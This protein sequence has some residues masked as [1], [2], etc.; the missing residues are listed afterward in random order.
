MNDRA[1]TVANDETLVELIRPASRRVV[2]MAPAVSKPVADAIKQKWMMLGA[3]AVSVIVDVDP[4]V[5]RLGYGDFEALGI[6]EQTAASLGTTLNRQNGIRI[7]LLISDDTTVVYSPTP[8][9]IE[10]GPEKISTPNAVILDSPPD[11]VAS[12]LGQGPNGIKDQT[13]GLDKAEKAKIAE[14]KENLDRNPPQRFDIAR[15]CRVFN[16][17]FEFVEFELPGL[18]IQQRKVTIPSDLIGLIKDKTIQ[19]M[20]E[21]SFKLIDESSELSGKAFQKCKSRIIKEYLTLLPGYKYVVLR[22]VKPKFVRKV[23]QLT[24]AVKRFQEHV[25]ADLQAAVDDNRKKLVDAW[26][27]LVKESPPQRWNK[28]YGGM[29]SDQLARKLLDNDL[30][31]AFLSADSLV[32]EMKVKLVFKGVTYELLQ[33][34]EFINLAR[35]RLPVLEELYYEFEAAKTKEKQ[36]ATLF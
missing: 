4:E 33:D 5:Y 35:Q 34:E 11:Q 27:P 9:L 2:F 18:Q 26:L 22:S 10:A 14:V 20:L 21:T 15:T 17:Y 16:A 7:G 13:I 6:L 32:N 8:Q 12:E 36:Q 30:Q 29:L 25:K 19:R 28:H 23:E 31:K 24:K 3:E 1:I